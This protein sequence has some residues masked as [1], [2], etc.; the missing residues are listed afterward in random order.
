MQDYER[1]LEIKW[2]NSLQYPFTHLLLTIKK[3]C[4]VRRV[5]L[6]IPFTHSCRSEVGDISDIDS[7][8]RKSAGEKCLESR[9]IDVALVV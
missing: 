8:Q 1:I 5:G 4:N 7:S 6:G 3:Y 9:L 2:K